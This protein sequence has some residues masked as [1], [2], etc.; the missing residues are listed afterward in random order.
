MSK[1]TKILACFCVSVIAIIALFATGVFETPVFLDIYQDKQYEETTKKPA[2]T[3]PQL[4]ASNDGSIVI[5][6][7]SSVDI[8]SIPSALKIK[9]TGDY[10]TA[11]NKATKNS[12]LLFQ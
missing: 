2:E 11:Y 9:L 4:G 10:L 7:S 8:N 12:R 3:G 6:S 1:F 5:S